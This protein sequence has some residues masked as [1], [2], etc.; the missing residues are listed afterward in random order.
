M[1]RE[2]QRLLEEEQRLMREKIQ[3]QMR[4]PTSNFDSSDTKYEVKLKWKAKKDDPTNGGYNHDLLQ[5]ILSKVNI[6]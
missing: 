4:Q 1:E 6:L 5:R 3:E 2:G